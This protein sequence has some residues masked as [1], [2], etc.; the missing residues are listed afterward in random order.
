M[1]D[2][3]PPTPPT[4][5]DRAV[6][7]R[8]QATPRPRKSSATPHTPRLK[9]HFP[10][11]L[12]YIYMSRYVTADQVRARFPDTYRTDRTSR[13][14]RRHLL[15]LFDLGYIARVNPKYT[16]PTDPHVHICTIKG[17]KFLRQH[18]GHELVDA[19]EEARTTG[20]SAQRYVNSHRNSQ[21]GGTFDGCQFS[22]NDQ[23]AFCFLGHRE[24]SFR[25]SNRGSNS[26]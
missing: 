15:Q 11:L 9:P 21:S 4:A 1:A 8:S 10:H 19:R 3:I 14:C 25:V 17:T 26:V 7:H 2:Q 13:S 23:F 16:S 6:R 12:R 5:W 20:V 18:F 22:G 24:G